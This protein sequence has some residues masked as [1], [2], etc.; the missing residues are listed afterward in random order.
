MTLNFLEYCI[1]D[2]THYLI[3][4][5]FDEVYPCWEITDFVIQDVRIPLRENSNQK[6][7]IQFLALGFK[8]KKKTPKS[9]RKL[10]RN[11]VKRPLSVHWI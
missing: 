4:G 11:Y 5:N 1:S 10:L 3:Y 8:R 7:V 9:E 6:R 2:T